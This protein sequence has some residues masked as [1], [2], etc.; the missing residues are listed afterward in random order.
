MLGLPN[1][2]FVYNGYTYHVN[3]V[4]AETTVPEP[5]GGILL[6]GLLGLLGGPAGAAVG[7]VAGGVI[8]SS[9]YEEDKAK[10][11]AFNNFQMQD[12]KPWL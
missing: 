12:W 5:V 1:N 2:R 11:D 9:Q 6:G 8:F 4:F 7:A 3:D 10:V